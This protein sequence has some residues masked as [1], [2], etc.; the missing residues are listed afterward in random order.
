[1]LTDSLIENKMN[2]TSATSSIF[3]KSKKADSI[4]RGNVIICCHSDYILSMCVIA[5][6]F[7]N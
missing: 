6:N 1:M 7:E 3:I 5:R 4:N 2:L